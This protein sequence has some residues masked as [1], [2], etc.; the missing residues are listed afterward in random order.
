MTQCV[1]SLYELNVL[2][3]FDKLYCTLH[4]R[5]KNSFQRG[6]GVKDEFQKNFSLNFPG[7]GG[8]GWGLGPL[9][10]LLQHVLYSFKRSA[11]V[12]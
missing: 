7:G 11:I 3:I 9:S 8:R 4:E 1:S 12:F 6:G 10:S 5:I 2:V